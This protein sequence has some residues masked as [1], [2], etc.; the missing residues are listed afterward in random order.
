LLAKVSSA[1]D[2]DLLV[3]RAVDALGIRED[4]LRR[5]LVKSSH[6]TQS[7][8]STMMTAAAFPEDAAER[9][10]VRMLL[11]CPAAVAAYT[12]QQGAR[13][14]IPPKWREVVDLIV[15]EW[16]EQGNIDVFRVA[17]KLSP[18]RTSDIAALAFQEGN[19]S[20]TECVAMAMDCL[21]HLRRRYLRSLERNL[22]V[23]I[24]TAE[25]QKDE[26]AKRE[27]ILEWQDV[28]RQ[29][30]QLERRKPEVKTGLP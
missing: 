7:Q 26:K 19:L 11:H 5:P 18:D 24:R 16:Q 25:E 23:A 20:E 12:T 15:A 6:E 2:A 29:E 22:R 14:C 13:Q 8:R 4:L 10:L 30:R 27:R 3:A 28:V 17:Q 21:T 1:L 9:S